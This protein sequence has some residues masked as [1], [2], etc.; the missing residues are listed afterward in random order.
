MRVRLTSALHLCHFAPERPLLPCSS[1]LLSKVPLHCERLPHAKTFSGD[2]S[3][4]GFKRLCLINPVEKPSSHDA[5][6]GPSKNETSAEP[7][8]AEWV[9]SSES[10]DDGNGIVPTASSNLTH[11]KFRDRNPKDC[12]NSFQPAGIGKPC[13]ANFRIAKNRFRRSMRSLCSAE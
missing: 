7:F 13:K 4:V 10:W 5:L 12:E 2:L 3:N 1:R 6:V 9:E 8:V 11:L